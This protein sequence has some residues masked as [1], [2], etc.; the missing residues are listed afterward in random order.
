VDAGPGFRVGGYEFNPLIFMPDGEVP[1]DLDRAKGL[2]IGPDSITHQQVVG[3][4]DSQNGNSEEKAKTEQVA[5]HRERQLAGLFSVARKR[6]LRSD[7]AAAY[8]VRINPG[9]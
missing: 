8:A 9:D 1:F 6:R 7:W 5:F 3:Y 4:I 2:A